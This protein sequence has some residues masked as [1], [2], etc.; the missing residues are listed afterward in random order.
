MRG[1]RAVVLFRL[2]DQRRASQCAGI[3]EFFQAHVFRREAEFLGVHKLYPGLGAGRD[4]P[5]RL[6]EVEAERLLDHDMLARGGGI[7]HHLAMQMV[8]HTDDDHLNRGL[9]EQLAVIGEGMGNPK[10]LGERRGVAR[11][12]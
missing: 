4:H 2:L 12:R 6:R 5:V 7:E 3:Q 9:R 10:A 8:G 11:R 1:V